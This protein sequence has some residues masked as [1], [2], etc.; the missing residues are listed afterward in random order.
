MEGLIPPVILFEKKGIIVMT[1]S[2][3][4]RMLDRS[5]LECKELRVKYG[6]YDPFDSEMFFQSERK[7]YGSY[8]ADYSIV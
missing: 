2:A 8:R 4:I 3:V 6:Y 1:N 5:T 7:N